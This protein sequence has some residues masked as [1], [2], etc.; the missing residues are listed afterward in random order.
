M[1]KS[2][3]RIKQQKPIEKRIPL[4]S[5][6]EEGGISF[7]FRYLDLSK[8]K[9]QV[10]QGFAAEYYPVFIDRLK[11]LSS[12][13]K[14]EL[15]SNRSSS[16]RFEPIDFKMTSEQGGF[17]I[18][19]KELWEASS[20]QVSVTANKYGRLHGFFLNY[21]SYHVFHIVWLDPNHM[22]FPSK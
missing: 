20:Y 19:N 1:S 8:E 18:P 2:K 16:L 17:P 11:A 10:E 6:P 22:L 14:Q 5:V 9:F 3:R 15:L 13:R 4:P 12:M 7:S 21:E